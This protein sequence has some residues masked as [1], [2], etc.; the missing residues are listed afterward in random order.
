MIVSVVICVYNEA[1]NIGPLVE[2]LRSALR[3]RSYEL[4]YVNDGS[5]DGTLAELDA[6]A[7]PELVIVDLAR[8]YGQSQALAAGFAVAQG[9]W[10]VTLDG[11][12]QHDPAD[13]PRLLTLA[14]SGGYDMVG[15]VRARRQDGFWLRKVPSWVANALIR[16]VTGVY[17]HD[18]GSSLRVFRTDLAKRLPLYGELHRFMPV[19][20]HLEGARMTEVPVHHRARLHGA[21]KYGL[22]RTMKVISDL[23]LL[24]FLKRYGLKPMHFFGHGSLYMWAVSGLLY[25]Y[26]GWHFLTNGVRHPSLLAP[27]LLVGGFQFL[28]M[29]LLAE[30]LLRLYYNS[31]QRTTYRIRNLT[32]KS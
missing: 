25:A 29:G 5:T 3:G 11:D 26:D 17:L 2:E 18:Y 8:N 23:M 9:T 13:I 4:I 1:G 10:V 6:L 30:L 15:S 27:L 22:G 24:V 16:R 32:K 12:L 31:P 14:E 7:A 19:L 20:A 28:G 21:S